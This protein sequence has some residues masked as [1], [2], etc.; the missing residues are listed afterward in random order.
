MTASWTRRRPAACALLLALAPFARADDAPLP[1]TSALDPAAS[2]VTITTPDPTTRSG[3]EI[4]QRFR[5]GLAEPDCPAGSNPRWRE[6]FAGAP[7][8]LATPEDDLLPLFGY[9]VDA[10][11]EAHLPT[12]YALI[13]FVESGYRPN[14]RSPSGPLGLWQFIAMTAR[15]HQ[16]AIRP[17]YDGRLSPVDSTRAAVRYLKTLHGMFAGDWRLAAM[18][19]NAGEYR[20]LGALRR[21]GQHARNATPETLPGL[22]GI[23]HA[24]VQKLRALSCLM[25]QADEREDW[26]RAL[27]R[28]VPVLAAHTLPAR[29]G[30]LDHWADQRGFDTAAIRRLN[31]VFAHGDIDHDDGSL[32]VLAPR[33]PAAA[34]ALL[35]GVAPGAAPMPGPAGDAMPAP[36]A[37]TPASVRSHTVSLGESAW[38]IARRY[39]IATAEL[40]ARNRLTPRSV[41]KPGMVLHIDAVDLPGE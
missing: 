27:D 10:L 15:S 35:A 2:A 12:E 30:N 40:L 37:A 6:H 5:D 38:T 11:R 28:P 22:S 14:A 32:R 36:A 9:V 33:L 18:A 16:V 8:Q 3:G 29:A 25:A 26:L 4:Y 31:P 24:Y 21:A 23:T 34:E 7:R 17:G 41:L 20:L 13:P 1:D 39:G 19:Y